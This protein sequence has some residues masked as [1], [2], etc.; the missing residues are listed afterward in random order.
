MRRLSPLVLFFACVSFA[1]AE[2]DFPQT[3]SGQKSQFSSNDFRQTGAGAGNAGRNQGSPG[4]VMNPINPNEQNWNNQNPSDQ[5]NQNASDKNSRDGSGP[6]GKAPR[7]N[8]HREDG[9]MDHSEDAPDESSGEAMSLRDVRVNFKT[10]VESF[11]ETKSVGGYWAYREKA[12]R[13]ARKLKFVSIDGGSV[14]K[15]GDGVYTGVGTMRE[16]SGR[17]SS[18]E[19]KVDFTGASWKVISVKPRAAKAGS[20]R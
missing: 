20:R 15:T 13:K 8:D 9:S 17:R 16:P 11:V 18:L 14:K 4:Q 3:G 19:F 2:S 1:V 6:N 7:K 10:V 5:N 12:G